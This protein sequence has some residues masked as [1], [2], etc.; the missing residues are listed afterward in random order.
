ML[1]LYD[2]CAVLQVLAKFPVVQ[3]VLFGSLLSLKPAELKTRGPPSLSLGMGPPAKKL[4]GKI[5]YS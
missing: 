2:V 5:Y 1:T 4:V 3:H